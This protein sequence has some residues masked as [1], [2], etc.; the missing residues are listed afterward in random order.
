MIKICNIYA[1]DHKFTKNF[2][3]LSGLIASFI[4]ISCFTSIVLFQFNILQITI[5]ILLQ[6]TIPIFIGIIGVYCGMCIQFS[7]QKDK[8]EKN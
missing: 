2:L 5:P 6:I 8:V 1:D 3:I 4:I 7:R